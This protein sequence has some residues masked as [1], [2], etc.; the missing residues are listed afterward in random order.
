LFN[1]AQLKQKIVNL[2]NNFDIDMSIE[3]TTTKKDKDDLLDYLK[4]NFGVYEEQIA[5]CSN[6]IFKRFNFIEKYN[7]NNTNIKLIDLCEILKNHEE[8]EAKDDSKILTFKELRN[9]DYFFDRSDTTNGSNQ[10]NVKSGILASLLIYY[11]NNCDDKTEIKFKDKLK[12]TISI[13]KTNTGYYKYLV[14]DSSNN[15][16]F[17][18]KLFESI[19]DD[20]CYLIFDELYY[21]KYD[22]NIFIFLDKLNAL[23]NRLENYSSLNFELTFDKEY[24]IKLIVNANYNNEE[25]IQIDEIDDKYIES[26]IIRNEK[27][28][29]KESIFYK[30]KIFFN[31]IFK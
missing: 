19:L 24:Q 14:P 7:K 1:K 18:C 13:F 30:I 29:L 3:A 6:N 15:R 4:T 23:L 25:F 26:K 9:I 5:H 12:G 28:N 27:V 31:S 20:N 2:I 10:K 21:K 17:G 22:D 8:I 11:R 16:L